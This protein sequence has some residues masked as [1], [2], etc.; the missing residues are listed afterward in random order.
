MRYVLIILVIILIFTQVAGAGEKPIIVYATPEEGKAILTAHDDFIK[1]MSPFDRAL[2][3]R[4][5]KPVSTQ[6]FVDFIGNNVM[7]WNNEDKVSLQMIVNSMAVKLAPYTSLLPDKIYLIK[8][9]GNEEGNSAYTR[10][11]AIIIPQQVISMNPVEIYRLMSHEIFHIMTRQNKK[12][13]EDLYSAIGFHTC[14]DFRLPKN[15]EK[16]R[17]T[18]P[19]A[20]FNN[21]CITV[22]IGKNYFDV[23]PLLYSNVDSYSPLHGEQ[24]FDYLQAGF[25][26]VAR[27]NKSGLHPVILKEKDMK[28]YKEEDLKGFFEKVGKNTDYTIHPEEI[29]ADNFS[30]LFFGMTEIESP[31]VLDKIKR[32]L[33]KYASKPAG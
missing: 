12:M 2:R 27:V 24:L 29:L 30:Y 32:V 31:E 1:A 16:R 3:M 8:T 33:D 22:G 21:H 23:I 26:S 28:L 5:E 11:N 13:T 25:L 6:E 7:A 9:T 18:N 19:D 15:L 20:P 4:S 14:A 17:L 10:A